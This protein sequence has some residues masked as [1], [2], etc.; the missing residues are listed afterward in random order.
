MLSNIKA[1]V[2]KCWKNET[3]NLQP[4][5]H[6]IDQTVM[7]RVSGTVERRKD[8]MIA[9]TVSIPLVP[10]LALFFEK[11]GITRDHA[12]RMLREAITE[13]ITNGKD[14]DE[15]IQARIIELEAAMSAIKDDLI[16][17]LPKVA[18]KGAVITKNLEIEVVPL[19]TAS[20]GD[21]SAAA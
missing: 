11:S 13:A 19:T 16:A 8:T 4:G 7:V 17:K 10:T 20:A 3:I 15:E 12:L 9:P 18:R 14:K 5:K 6:H 21:E 1:L 2:A